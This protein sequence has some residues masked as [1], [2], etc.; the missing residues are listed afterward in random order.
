V[1]RGALVSAALFDGPPPWYVPDAPLPA[2][3]RIAVIAPHPD[4]FDVIGITMRLFQRA[5]ATITLGVLTSGASG[6]EDAFEADP[7]AKRR[8]R[9]REQE[10]SCEFFGLPRD[11]LHFL[12]LAEDALGRLDDGEANRERVA[13]F[14][15]QCR[16]EFVFLPHG[17]DPNLAHQRTFAMVVGALSR[18]DPPVTMWLNRDPKTIAMREDVYVVFDDESAEWKRSLLRHHA[19]QQA[20]N[21]RTRGD[22]FD[23]RI[24]RGDAEVARSAQRPG[25]F[26]ETFELRA[27]RR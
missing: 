6:V 9:E 22:G 18:Q 10:A 7:D 2:A 17:S 15:S 19:S 25:A 14:L 13:D 3:S 27:T 1:E 26:A 21:V 12:R 24:L 4:D 20:R 11:R 16:P 5:S 8:V 23:E